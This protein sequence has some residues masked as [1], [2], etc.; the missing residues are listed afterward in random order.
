MSPG[1]MKL[2]RM[3]AR[4]SFRIRS[5]IK[6]RVASSRLFLEQSEELPLRRFFMYLYN[7]SALL[8]LTFWAFCGKLRSTIFGYNSKDFRMCNQ[9]V[10]FMEELL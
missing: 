8:I 5:F 6:S 4:S 7:E 9:S 1:S 2:W 3:P 10:I